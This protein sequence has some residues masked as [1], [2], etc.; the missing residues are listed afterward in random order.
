LVK[1]GSMTR[2]GG[3][4][5]YTAFSNEVMGRILGGQ[6][7][8]KVGNIGFSACDVVG[9]EGVHMRQSMGAGVG[10]MAHNTSEQR[11]KEAYAVSWTCP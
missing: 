9:H 6:L 10:A 3:G 2:T 11:E 8:G 1:E 4:T 5:S 7:N